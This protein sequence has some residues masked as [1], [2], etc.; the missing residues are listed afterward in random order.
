MNDK[1]SKNISSEFAIGMVV[2]IAILVA[3]IFWLLSRKQIVNNERIM[4]NLESVQRASL[5]EKI[6]EKTVKADENK[7]APSECKPRYFEGKSDVRAWI[8]NTE[9]DTIINIKNEDAKNLPLVMTNLGENDLEVKIVDL[10]DQI[11]A[12]LKKATKQEPAKIAVRGYAETCEKMPL[13]SIGDIKVI[14][15]KI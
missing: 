15:K 5:R 8:G 12:E 10:T 9:E 2:I 13:V 1:K 4:R 6:S 7:E 3:I 14:F 11:K